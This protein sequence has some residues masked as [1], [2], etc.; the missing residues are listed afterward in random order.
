MYGYDVYGY[1]VYGYDVY[2]Y[3][4]C[5]CGAYGSPELGSVWAPEALRFS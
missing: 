1:G 3:G 5:R 4:V 2:E